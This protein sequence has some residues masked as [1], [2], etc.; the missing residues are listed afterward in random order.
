[1]LKLNNFLLKKIFLYILGI[2]VGIV[3]TYYSALFGKSIGI[4]LPVCWI[5]AFILIVMTNIIFQA[6]IKS[7]MNKNIFSLIVF[8]IIWIIFIAFSIFGTIAGIWYQI[9]L[10]Q[11]DRI[12]KVEYEIKNDPE[13]ILLDNQII[14]I[15]NDI[16]RYQEQL[17]TNK[18]VVSVYE[19]KYTTQKIEDDLKLAQINFNEKSL[20]KIEIIKKYKEIVTKNDFY[21]YISIQNRWKLENIKIII[22][23]VFGFI[24]DISGCLAILFSWVFE[25]NTIKNK[26]MNNIENIPIIKDNSYYIKSYC[27][28]RYPKDGSNILTGRDQ[29]LLNR[30]RMTVTKYQELTEIAKNKGLI[31]IDA[32]LKVTK[33]NNHLIS[34][35]EFTQIMLK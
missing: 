29:Q 24:F 34:K 14:A 17:K 13:L 30:Y 16:D 2:C 1:M 28:M 5:S 10:Q 12:K 21:V 9:D 22:A 32:K 31:T 26:Y 33:L 15:Q 4:D 23:A 7:I 11:N 35:E 19:Y 25:N 20:K 6:L 3:S 8:G 18:S 27:E